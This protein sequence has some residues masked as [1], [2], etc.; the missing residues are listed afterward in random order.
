MDLFLFVSG[1]AFAE[2]RLGQATISLN[3]GSLTVELPGCAFEYPDRF[4]D[5][6]D[7]AELEKAF[8]SVVQSALPR[9]CPPASTIAIISHCVSNQ[10][11]SFRAE[12]DSGPDLS[13]TPQTYPD[14]SAQWNTFSAIAIAVAIM[15]LSSL[16]R[17]F[18][19]PEDWKFVEIKYLDEPSL[20]MLFDQGFTWSILNQEKNALKIHRE[21]MAE[22]PP[23]WTHTK[24][25]DKIAAT[26][27]LIEDKFKRFINDPFTG[28]PQNR[29]EVVTSARFSI[30]NGIT[31]VTCRDRTSRVGKLIFR[32]A[33]SLAQDV[34]VPEGFLVEI[35]DNSDVVESIRN[36]KET[37]E[38]GVFLLCSEMTESMGETVRALTLPEPESF[39][40]KRSRKQG[41]RKVTL[42]EKTELQGVTVDYESYIEEGELGGVFKGNRAKI[43]RP[44]GRVGSASAEKKD[45][46]SGASKGV[47]RE[48]EKGLTLTI[49]GPE[50]ICEMSFAWEP[51]NS[52]STE[53]VEMIKEMI[54]SVFPNTC[55]DPNSTDKISGLEKLPVESTVSVQAGR[56]LLT[57]V[58]ENEIN[59]TYISDSEGTDNPSHY[60][61]DMKEKLMDRLDRKNWGVAVPIRVQ[62][63]FCR[64]LRDW[65]STLELLFAVVDQRWNAKFWGIQQNIRAA[66]DFQDDAGSVGEYN[67]KGGNIVVK[68]LIERKNRA[69]SFLAACSCAG[70]ESEMPTQGAVL[71]QVYVFARDMIEVSCSTLSLGE[72]PAGV[73]RLVTKKTAISGDLCEGILEQWTRIDGSKT[74]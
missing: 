20:I 54:P 30:Q 60:E 28:T 57:C 23:F 55:P 74:N 38:R 17:R 11:G 5:K 49:P 32:G 71:R 34:E 52:P 50:N 22:I 63:R 46:R 10:G 64:V 47:E 40:V 13:V 41:T 44:S 9:E 25:R 24:Q 21:L 14:C 62:K 43:K 19:Y 16:Q 2:V 70:C 6:P 65:S 4:E 68:S 66:W 29:K 53:H 51:K 37:I 12:K 58:F 7:T 1:L 3:T 18:N 59:I 15:H 45:H 67:D 36:D 73:I 31:T 72:K 33:I 42:N 69:L 26:F 27:L 39:E 35:G 48:K 56:T 61:S 8:I